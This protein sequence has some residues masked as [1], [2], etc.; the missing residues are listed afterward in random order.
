MNEEGGY[1]GAMTY[2]CLY[3]GVLDRIVQNRR[4]DDTAVYMIQRLRSTLRQADISSPSFLFDFTKVLLMDS[5]LNVNLQEAFLRR[6][7]TAPTDDLELPNLRQREYQELSSRAIAL[8]RVLARVPEEMSDRRTFLETIKEIASSIK[9]LLDATNAVMQVIHPSVQ[10][11]VEKRKRE[12]VHYSKRFSNTLKEYFK[13]QN[14]TQVS[15]SANQLIFQTV[16]LIRT[17]REKM[18]KVSSQKS[19][20]SIEVN[21]QLLS[22]GYKCGE[23]I[24]KGTYSKVQLA[25][26]K[27]HSKNVAIKIINRRSQ[28]DFIIRFLPREL[29][30]LPILSHSNIIETYEVIDCGS[31][32]FII[33]EYAGGRDLLYQIKKKER[34]S[35]NISKFLFRQLLEALMYLKTLEIA[36]RDLKCENI[37]LDICGNIKLG[38]FGFSRLMHSND[39][40]HTFCGSRAYVPPEV[41]RSQPYTGFFVDLWSAGVVLF[42]MVTGLMPY[43]DQ[44]P[45]RMLS[46]QLQHRLTFPRKILLSE[47]VKTLIYEILHP[48]P[49]QRKQYSDILISTW[50]ADTPYKFRTTNNCNKDDILECL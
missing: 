5:E 50:L 15:T 19:P 46:K 18:R 4:N 23:I 27:K 48:I 38:D 40:S 29:Q 28:T 9:K 37:F 24:G 42:V 45:R 36:H 17:I 1:L 34:L 10:L 22:S 30:I 47:E 39:I 8:R 33:Q 31:T 7:A 11:S 25:S 35:E 3:S 2:Q 49:S 44:N 13:D 32:V 43:D 14:A 21:N 26:S 12:F 16:L 20:T 6:Q 41:L